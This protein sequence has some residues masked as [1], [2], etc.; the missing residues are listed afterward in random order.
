MP[1]KLIWE[2][3]GTTRVMPRRDKAVVETMLAE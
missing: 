3:L 2:W 1:G